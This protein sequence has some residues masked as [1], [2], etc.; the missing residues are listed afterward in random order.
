[1]RGVPQGQ[2]GDI[3]LAT[4]ILLLLKVA[5]QGQ[6]VHGVGN[7]RLKVKLNPCQGHDIF[8]LK[9]QFYDCTVDVID[10]F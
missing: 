3:L 10:P 6:H 4:G 5:E 7:G 8:K 1:M 9:I 2:I